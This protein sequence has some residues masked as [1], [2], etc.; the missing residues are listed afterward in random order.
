MALSVK[1]KKVATLP[2]DPQYEINT[3]E[4]NDE[5]E[6]ELP[7]DITPEATPS[8]AGIVLADSEG[9][10]WLI[11]VTTDGNLSAEELMLP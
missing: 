8:F 11:T 9:K 4:W 5:H 1:H 7:Q 2:D 10:K 6:V 3:T